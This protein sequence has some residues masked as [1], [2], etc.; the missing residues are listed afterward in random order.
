MLAEYAQLDLARIQ[1]DK[2]GNMAAAAEAYAKFET[3]FPDS[4]RGATALVALARIHAEEKR[5][6]EAILACRLVISKYPETDD[7][8]TATLAIADFQAAAGEKDKAKAQYEAARAMAQDWH[9]N[10]YGIDVGKQ[11]WLRGLLD[12]IRVK[13]DKLG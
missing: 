9:D 2:L 7:V 4:A 13:L 1:K 5:V 8:M 10:K 12:D 11:A 6:E 3:I